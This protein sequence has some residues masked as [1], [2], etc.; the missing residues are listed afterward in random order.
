MGS[1]VTTGFGHE[2]TRQGLWIDRIM[3]L[4]EDMMSDLSRLTNIGWGMGVRPGPA[5]LAMSA[6][7]S[8]NARPE[9][10]DH[11]SISIRDARAESEL[12][13]GTVAG[14]ATRGGA[15]GAASAAARDAAAG[16]DTQAPVVVIVS[17]RDRAAL[18]VAAAAA[19]ADGAKPPAA[20]DPTDP[21]RAQRAQASTVAASGVTAAANTAKCTLSSCFSEFMYV[22]DTG[23]DWLME[24]VWAAEDACDCME[25]A[26]LPC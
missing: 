25:D 11:M 4:S 19:A 21:S 15:A 2:T 18:A 3:G 10:P 13:W 8:D 17:P 23:A 12:A 24:L 26:P 6:Q 16:A 5:G 1:G 14:A 7:S 20:P 9:T 22:V